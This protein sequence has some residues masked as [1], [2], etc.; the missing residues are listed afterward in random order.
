MTRSKIAERVINYLACCGCQKVAMEDL[1]ASVI[2]DY[3]EGMDADK[4]YGMVKPVLEGL[5]ENDLVKLSLETMST[6]TPVPRFICI[7]PRMKRAADA[8]MQGDCARDGQGFGR[9][10]ATRGRARQAKANGGYKAGESKND[11]VAVRFNAFVDLME[12]RGSRVRIG[13]EWDRL[14]AMLIYQEM[15]EYTGFEACGELFIKGLIWQS[16]RE[17]AGGSILSASENKYEPLIRPELLGQID[18]IL[19][20]DAEKNGELKARKTCRK[21]RKD[22]LAVTGLDPAEIQ[23]FVRCLNSASARIRPD[24]I[25]QLAM[26]IFFER[27]LQNETVYDACS[28]SFRAGVI[29]QMHRKMLESKA[30]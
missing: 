25:W 8:L 14:I 6:A 13:G 26:G 16:R 18:A 11:A 22:D 23:D 20:K 30:A 10:D 7:R 27:L 12:K 29:F 28:E 5:A 19:S 1:F 4:A 21:Q 2:D 9:K 3:G 24:E 17:Q 15:E